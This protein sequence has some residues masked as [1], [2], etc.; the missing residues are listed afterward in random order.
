M[1]QH[2]ARGFLF[3]FLSTRIIMQIEY[4]P[5]FDC[6]FAILRKERTLETNVVYIRQRTETPLLPFGR[7]VKMDWLHV[8]W[9]LIP[10]KQIISRKE[11]DPYSVETIDAHISKGGSTLE[12]MSA[13]VVLLEG[14]LAQVTLI[15]GTPIHKLPSVSRRVL[16]DTLI[17]IFAHPTLKVSHDEEVAT[18]QTFLRDQIRTFIVPLKKHIEYYAALEI[19][20]HTI[21][22]YE[23]NA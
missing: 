3:A 13:S 23:I 10:P 20:G 8:C 17:Q 11:Y 21:V 15:M 14:V 22:P 2:I 7:P 9:D 18:H 16:N 12:H 19:G 5:E 6:S 4:P 1:Y